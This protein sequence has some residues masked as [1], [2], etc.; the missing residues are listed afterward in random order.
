M[1]QVCFLPECCSNSIPPW[2]QDSYR[3]AVPAP[4]CLPERRPGAFRRH[5]TNACYVTLFTQ[6]EACHTV[7]QLSP[8]SEQP[9]PAVVASATSLSSEH[10]APVVVHVAS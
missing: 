1:P 3:S 6:V 2:L 10:P 5:Y 4:K 9:S 8:V 7:R